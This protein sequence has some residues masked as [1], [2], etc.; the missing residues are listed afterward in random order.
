V[1]YR[2]NAAGHEAYLVGGGVRDLLLGHRPKDFDVATRA[3]PEEVKALFGNARIIGR[4]FRLAH[5]RFGR[6]VIEV[7]TFRASH[8]NGEGGG[9]AVSDRG[10]LLSDNVYG[11]REEDAARRDF[12]VNCLYY[13]VR[14][15]SVLSYLGAIDDLRAG[16]LR[17]IGDP[18]TRYRE[19]PVRLLRV[20]RF[21]AKLGFSIAP[22]SEEPVRPLVH[23]LEDIPPARLFEEVLKLFMTGHA[24][25]SLELL[26]GYGVFAYLFPPT[27]RCL[28]GPGPAPTGLRLVERAL[29]N[30]DLRLAAEKPVTPGF[31]FAAL[32]WPAVCAERERMS[33]LGEDDPVVAHDEAVAN[34]LS[35]QLTHVSLS[36][37]F[38]LMAREIWSLQSRL[39][40]RRKRGAAR[41][42]AHPRFRAAYDFLLLRAEAGEP[43][44]AAAEWWT[45]FQA[46]DPEGRVK[47]DQASGKGRRRGPRRRRVA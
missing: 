42:V 33:A 26:R 41:M 20:L 39:E 8:R 4:R 35:E 3:T 16:V 44:A 19:D 17:M 23:L 10:R 13:D 29:T 43:V 9:V 40:R 47:G 2:L 6:E 1:L 28:D 7:A 45:E 32:L 21:A 37:R 30:T 5:V 34:V 24:T 15:F 18:E 11:S 36:R 31:L 46:H 22:E 25:A 12:T 27:A 38:S 14:D